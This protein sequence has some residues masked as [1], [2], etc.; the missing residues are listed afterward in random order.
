MKPL[1]ETVGDYIVLDWYDG[2][3]LEIARVDFSDGDR[4]I[5]VCSLCTA[6]PEETAPTERLRGTVHGDYPWTRATVRLT[7]EHLQAMLD[8]MDG[9]P[10]K[11]FFL[12][13]RKE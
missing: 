9:K 6:R 12:S 1:N 10:V 5:Q 8:L 7:R 11:D 3:L 4:L 13:E 2:P